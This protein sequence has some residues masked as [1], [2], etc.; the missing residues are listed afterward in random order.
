[1]VLLETGVSVWKFYLSS[2][3]EVNTFTQNPFPN[4]EPCTESRS[5][6]CCIILRI[7]RDTE[8]VITEDFNVFTNYP[9]VFSPEISLDHYYFRLFLI[10]WRLLSLGRFVVLSH[11]TRHPLGRGEKGVWTR[12]GGNGVRST[13]G[14]KLE[15][16]L[17]L[18]VRI[19]IRWQDIQSVT[20][21]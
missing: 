21:N 10:K 6:D 3:L 12:C 7:N 9:S 8:Y 18:H 17:V 11:Y 16:V 15:D 13:R 1:M 2:N 20:N 4:S 19:G 5:I 14:S